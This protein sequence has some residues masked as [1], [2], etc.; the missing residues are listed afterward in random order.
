[1]SGKTNGRLAADRAH[2]RTAELLTE[3]NELRA[4]L[5]KARD[6]CRLLARIVHTDVLVMEAAAIE[7]RQGDT[8]A[9]MQWIL[10]ARP[11]QW[12][13]QPGTEWDGKETAQQWFDRQPAVQDEQPRPAVAAT[14]AEQ[15]V[16]EITRLAIPDGELA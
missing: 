2:E 7:M 8:H 6:A 1:M 16:A 11:D 4:E 14:F 3:V 10:N 13:G 12:D 15:L 5:A 9:A